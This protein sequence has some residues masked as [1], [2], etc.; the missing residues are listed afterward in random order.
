MVATQEVRGD[1]KEPRPGVGLGRVVAAALV[2]GDEEGLRRQ[3]V[4][5]VRADPPLQVGVDGVEMA[6]EDRREAGGGVKR[7]RDRFAVEG[8]LVHR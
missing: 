2:E 8:H 1:A 5:Q 4:G 7:G 6:I 3:L